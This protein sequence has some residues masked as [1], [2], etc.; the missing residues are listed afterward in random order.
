M[1]SSDCTSIFNYM[2][3]HDS[4]GNPSTWTAS[5]VYDESDCSNPTSNITI[6]GLATVV[7]TNVVTTG[8]NKEI[9][10]TV[11]CNNVEPG[12]GAARC[13]GP[14]AASPA[15]CNEREFHQ[16]WQPRSFRQD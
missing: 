4:D 13:T 6:V 7:I 14:W 1:D 3:T 15:W 2:K 8:A 12:R 16:G 9:D 10:A 11:V 5:V